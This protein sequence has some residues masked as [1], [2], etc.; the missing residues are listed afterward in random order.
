MKEVSKNDWILYEARKLELIELNLTPDE[1]EREVLKLA[2]E[3][4]I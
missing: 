1:Y 4:G 2:E 3:L